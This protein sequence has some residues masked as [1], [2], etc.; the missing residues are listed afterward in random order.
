MKKSKWSNLFGATLGAI[1]IGLTCVASK[2]AAKKY[3]QKIHSFN[4][5]KNY[6]LD[7]ALNKFLDEPKKDK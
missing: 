2:N 5:D 1:T 6:I 3:G 4:I 7:Y